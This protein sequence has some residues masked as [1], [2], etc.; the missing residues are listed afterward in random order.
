MTTLSAVIC[1][2]WM[3]HENIIRTNME[4][5]KT[6]QDG[7]FYRGLFFVLVAGLLIV[8]LIVLFRQIRR[9]PKPS[10]DVEF[11]TVKQT[12]S[13]NRISAIAGIVL[14]SFFFSLMSVFQLSMALLLKI[15]RLQDLPNLQTEAV[16]IQSRKS[17][18]GTILLVDHSLFFDTEHVIAEP[19]MSSVEYQ[20]SYLKNSH[21]LTDFQELP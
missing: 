9:T 14:I 16:I 5:W 21:I 3:L 6:I 4:N 19:P 2:S 10:G 13:L 11:S 18:S 17:L 20:I 7:F 1:T 12:K 15:D 8:S